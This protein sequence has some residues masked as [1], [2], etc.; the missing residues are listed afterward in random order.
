MV[1][2]NGGMEGKVVLITGGT[3]GIG[4]AAATALAA[5]GAEVVVSGRSRER[6]E[7]AV[8]E[9]RDT[10]GNEKVSLMLAD[11][12]V[13]AEVRG[14]AEEFRDRYD[15]LDVLVNNAGII[16]S[17]RT[18]TPDGIELTLAV[19]HLAPFLLTNLLL[20]LLKESA[21][22]RIV[23]VS[24]E[25]RRGAQI[26]FD[27]LQSERR[28]RAFKVYG[29]TKLANILFTYELAERLE[30]T[31]VVANC[32][33]PGGVNTNF[34]NN[35]RSFGTLIFRAFK[36]FM[37][38]PEQGADTVVYLA[39]SPEAG[40]MTGRYLTDRKVVSTFQDPHDEVMQKRLWEVSE[41]LTNLEVAS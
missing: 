13:Q 11:L 8:E 26:D 24:S 29:M 41:E 25:A 33:H 10:S 18:Q 9:I 21:P 34:G 6:G 36:P 32:L 22:S 27:D 31:G 5:M 3:S 17:K 7:S 19:N 15:R 16:Q 1:P 14:L 20:D 38:T 39:V 28:Y 23:T 40:K 35:N 2:E 4:R 30:R 37:R 12:A